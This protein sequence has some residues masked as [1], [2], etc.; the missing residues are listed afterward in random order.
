MGATIQWPRLL[1]FDRNEVVYCTPKG[2][3]IFSGAGGRDDDEILPN[4]GGRRRGQ[5]SSSS[6]ERQRR[7]RTRQVPFPQAN[8]LRS[9]SQTGFG[10]RILRRYCLLAA[11]LCLRRCSSTALCSGMAVPTAPRHTRYLL[12]V[13]PLRQEP[14]GVGQLSAGI[15]GARPRYARTYASGRMLENL[16]PSAT[17]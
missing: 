12:H 13:A 5:V 15:C 16:A 9:L 8:P 17:S 10:V 7:R 14:F 11:W 6:M 3:E 1:Q 2:V 4:V